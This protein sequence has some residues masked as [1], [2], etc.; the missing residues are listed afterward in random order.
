MSAECQTPNRGLTCEP[1]SRLPAG[2]RLCWKTLTDP[3]TA[4]EARI[5]SQAKGLSTWELGAQTEGLEGWEG[6]G[7]EGGPP[8]GGGAPAGILHRPLLWSLCSH[9][10]SPARQE[11]PEETTAQRGWAAHLVIVEDGIGHGVLPWHRGGPQLLHEEHLVGER[12]HDSCGRGQSATGEIPAQKGVQP[13]PSPR[14][15]PVGLGPGPDP[16][17]AGPR[18]QTIPGPG[19]PLPSL[20][21]RAF[22]IQSV[23][24]R[25]KSKK[26]SFSGTLMT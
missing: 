4:A 14:P 11:H 7:P 5:Q 26:K 1:P 22:F 17:P 25:T 8:P 20:T 21:G 16:A 6:E 13:S 12:G 18:A 2:T 15:R 3:G 19:L 9:S 24:W 10:R 23:R